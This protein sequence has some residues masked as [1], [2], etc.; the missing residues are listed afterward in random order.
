MRETTKRSK[1]VRSLLYN[2]FRGN[3]ATRYGSEMEQVAIEQYTTY[4][5]RNFHPELRVDNCGLFISE[6][7]NWLA[8]TPD[9]V[10]HDPSDDAHP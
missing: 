10:V 4:Q 9:G 3:Q 1:K 5:R 7:N 8:A 6:H 2:T